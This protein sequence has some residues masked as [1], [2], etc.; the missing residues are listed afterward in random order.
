MGIWMGRRAYFLLVY[1]NPAADNIGI[2]NPA[3]VNADG[4]NEQRSFPRREMTFDIFGNT[5]SHSRIFTL[6]SFRLY[7]L[8]VF[9]AVFFV[10]HYF[11]ETD[12]FRGNLN[13]LIL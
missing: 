1:P 6:L 2:T 13:T 4:Y 8:R 10:E 11:A 7:H 12:A 5:F 9:L 3:A